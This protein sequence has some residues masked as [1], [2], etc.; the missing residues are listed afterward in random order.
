MPEPILCVNNLH[1]SIDKTPV[2]NGVSLSVGAGEVHVLM[3]PNGS[4]K[5]TFAAAI[6]GSP[7]VT[8]TSGTIGLMGIDITNDSPEARA[9]KG[10]YLGFQNP[11]ELAGVGMVPFLRS[12]LAS[13]GVPLDSEIIFK[14]RMGLTLQRTGLAPHVLDRNVNEGF[15]GGEKKRNEVFQLSVFNPRIAVMDEIDS[16]LDVDGSRIVG[17]ELQRFVAGGGSLLLI[18]HSV[19]SARILNPHRVYIMKGGRIVKQGDK[20]LIEFVEKNG[21]ESL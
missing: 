6:M 2:L 5:S 13:G 10:L 16:G 20:D 18:T 12:V 3:G 8:I 1:V 4:G 7:L 21:F 9:K 17:E 11:A 19:N 14:E 15:S